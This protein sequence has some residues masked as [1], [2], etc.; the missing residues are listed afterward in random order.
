MTRFA[1]A[2]PPAQAQ[3]KDVA[4][5]G[6]NL[7]LGADND[8]ASWRALDEKVNVYPCEREFKA[9]GTGG[10]DFVLS[11]MAAAAA[12]TGEQ[13]LRD[14]VVVRPSRTGK[15]LAVN[16]YVLVQDGEQVMAIFQRMQADT[17]MRFFL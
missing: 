5:L 17:R 11:M 15:Y 9:I 16:L 10:E 1:R 2:A 7:V 6:R 3:G 12:V 8:D 13:L 14:K 4:S